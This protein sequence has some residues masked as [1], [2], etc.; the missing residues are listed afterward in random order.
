M[1]SE[2][3]K[4]L[5]EQLSVFLNVKLAKKLIFK[6]KLFCNFSFQTFPIA[7]LSTTSSFLFST[8]LP[9]LLIFCIPPLV[10][11]LPPKNKGN[12]IMKTD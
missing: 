4:Y 3:S 7:P 6:R 9:I 10:P 12:E 11:S 8:S 2:L 5:N 1:T